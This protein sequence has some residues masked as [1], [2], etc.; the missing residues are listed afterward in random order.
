LT[1]TVQEDWFRY[2]PQAPD[3]RSAKSLVTGVGT[4]SQ[5]T[6]LFYDHLEIGRDVT[7][8]ELTPG[9]LL[10]DDQTVSSRH[11]LVTQAAGGRCFVRDV[12][13]N[14]TRVDGRRVMPNIE[15]EIR[16]G[17][18][19]SVGNDRQFLLAADETADARRPDAPLGAT[20]GMPGTTLASVLFGDIRNYTVVVQHAP[21]DI[22]RQSLSAVFEILT[23][24]VAEHG[25]TVK[26]YPGDAILA[27][28]E[29]N[30][31]GAQAVSACGAA[32]ALDRLVRRL[33]GDR[34]VWQLDGFPLQMEWGI[35]TGMVAIDSF[36]GSR[37]TGL[38]VIGE[39]IVLAARLEKLATE[40]T[41]PILVCSTTKAL[42]A[43][44][45]TFRDLG[46]I[47][48]KGF[49]RPERVFALQ[50]L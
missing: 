12:S 6:L 23:E 41:G 4:P 21:S 32:L 19:L 37:P 29:G 25:G 26:E 31:D 38:T 35:A 27:F 42:A 24:A 47:T 43:A 48:A 45:F 1:T 9:L 44:R 33:I 5:R 49:D 15:T 10:I 28:W 40:E 22:V 18:M 20:L 30:L 11:C 2:A 13:R 50:G 39:P 34:A 8:R 7:G 3:G 36:G 17:Q 14:G 16:A 46:Q